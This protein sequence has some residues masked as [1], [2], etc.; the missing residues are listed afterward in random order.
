MAQWLRTHIALAGDLGLVPSNHM[1]KSQPSVILILR[2][3]TPLLNAWT[4]CI[5]VAYIQVADI[6]L[7]ST[8]ALVMVPLRSNRTVTKKAGTRTGHYCERPDHDACCQNRED[9][10]ILG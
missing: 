9:F 5:R 4:P 1:V 8:G 7:S 6:K 10:G 2:D 3:L